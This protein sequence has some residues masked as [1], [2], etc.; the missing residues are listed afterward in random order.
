MALRVHYLQHVP[1]EGLGRIRPWAETAGAALT[2]TRFHQEDQPLPEMKAFDLL[3]IMGG[4]MS[5]HETDRYPWLVREKQFIRKAVAAGKSIL[6]ICLGAQLIAAALGARV[7]ANDYRE[8]GWYDIERTQA[9]AGHA[10]GDCL[11]AR[12]KVFHWHGDTFDPPAGALPL[13]SSA[14]CRNQGFAVGDR[15]VGLQ[16]HL[17]TTPESLQAL[18]ENGR[19]DLKPGP[20]VQSPDAMRAANEWYAPNHDVLEAILNRLSAPSS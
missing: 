10:I 12:I 9:A 11:P 4:P 20:Y 1:F 7:Y 2:A 13:A 14:A 3:V 17:E 5:T 16:F 19:G 18:I 8:I 15:V 6:G